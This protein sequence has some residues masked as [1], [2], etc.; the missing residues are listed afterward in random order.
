MYATVYFKK[1]KTLRLDFVH[2]SDFDSVPNTTRSERPDLNPNPTEI[3]SDLQNSI[4]VQDIIF[5]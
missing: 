2:I 3:G 5:F 4:P 1:L